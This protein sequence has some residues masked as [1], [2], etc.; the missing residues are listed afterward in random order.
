ML[1]S[2]QLYAKNS[3]CQMLSEV[4]TFIVETPQ[5]CRPNP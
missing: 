4:A 5:I 3:N 1:M 2:A